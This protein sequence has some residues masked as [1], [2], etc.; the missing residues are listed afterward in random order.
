[1]DNTAKV[2]LDLAFVPIQFHFLS[3]VAPLSP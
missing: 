1:M 2:E 3:P